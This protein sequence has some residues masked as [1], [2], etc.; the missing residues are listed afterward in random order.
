M[1]IYIG[2]LLSEL[3][4]AYESLL[5]V[6]TLLADDGDHFEVEADVIRARKLVQQ[7][8]ESI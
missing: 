4:R 5:S 3:D 6:E 2:L 8:M 1:S 7:I